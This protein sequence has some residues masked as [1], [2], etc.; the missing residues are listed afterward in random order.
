MNF[1]EFLRT[2]FFIKHLWWLLLIRYL[3]QTISV[4]RVSP[5][6]PLIDFQNDESLKDDWVRSQLLDIEEKGR[7]KPCEGKRPCHLCKS[8]ADTW[9]CKSKHF[10]MKCNKLTAIIIVIQKWLFVVSSRVCGE[11]YTGSTKT[12]FWSRANNYKIIHRTFMSKKKDQKK[13]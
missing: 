8:M 4:K 1:A 3:H 9:T 13:V 12:K 6:I 2:P 11:P 7:S 10:D 5:N